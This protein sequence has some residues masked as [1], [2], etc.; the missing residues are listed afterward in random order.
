MSCRLFNFIKF[1]YSNKANNASNKDFIQIGESD[2]IEETMA[3]N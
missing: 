3:H 2:E 1:I